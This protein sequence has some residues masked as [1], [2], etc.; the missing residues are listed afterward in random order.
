MHLSTH[1]SQN[2]FF[3][4]LPDSTHPVKSGSAYMDQMTGIGKFWFYGWYDSPDQVDVDFS[5]YDY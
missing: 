4:A 1:H 2:Q 5:K 3:Y